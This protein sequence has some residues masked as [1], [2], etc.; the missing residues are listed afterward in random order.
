MIALSGAHCNVLTVC[1]Q[2]LFKVRHTCCC[3]KIICA[4]NTG[5]VV[6]S[7]AVK[8]I[9]II[10]IAFLNVLLMNST[11]NNSVGKVFRNWTKVGAGVII[12]CAG[13]AQLSADYISLEKWFCQF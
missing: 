10:V 1:F 9:V 4:N 8:L 6:P 11:I 5:S 2:G 7:A 13:I 12:I 3:S